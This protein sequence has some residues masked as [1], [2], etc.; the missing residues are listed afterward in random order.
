MYGHQE[1]IQSFLPVSRG[2]SEGSSM[3]QLPQLLQR[4]RG[5]LGVIDAPAFHCRLGDAPVFILPPF[6]RAPNTSS[7]HSK[8]ARPSL[9]ACP[10]MKKKNLVNI[11]T[12]SAE[13]LSALDFNPL[14]AVWSQLFSEVQRN[15]NWH[16]KTFWRH[17]THVSECL[18][19]SRAL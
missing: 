19:G 9:T 13:C 12:P 8:R 15:R 1:W 14:S 16:F 18:Y 2:P 7:G 11:Q 4:C 17:P 5:N 6:Y 10:F 3:A